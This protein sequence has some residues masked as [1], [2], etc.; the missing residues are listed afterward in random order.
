MCWV[1]ITKKQALGRSCGGFATKIYAKVNALGNPLKFDFTPGQKSDISVATKL[2]EKVSKAYVV[3]DREYDFDNFIE[4]IESLCCT[5]VIPG[6]RNRKVKINYDTHIYKER[7][8]VEC[9]FSKIK[10]F[11]RIFSRF[12]KSL[13]SFKAFVC[14]VGSLVWL[15]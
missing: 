8:I 15:R 2:L 12:E 3:C 14:F 13:L 9:F 5:P 1:W 4:Q 11:R 10:Y 7:N 6:R